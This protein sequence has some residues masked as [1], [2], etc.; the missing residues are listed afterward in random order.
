MTIKTW[1]QMSN[2]RFISADEF[3]GKDV[4]LTI[5]DIWVE[6]LTDFDGQPEKGGVVAF[7]ETER[8]WRVNATNRAR[9]STIWP[10]PKAAIGR[11]VTLMA[12]P[13]SK[14]PTGVAIRVKGSPD[15]SGP[16]QTLDPIGMGKV[17]KFTL[18]KTADAATAAP[19]PKQPEPEAEPE[20]SA[21]SAACTDCGA[22]MFLTADATDADIAE[23]ACGDCGGSMRRL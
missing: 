7:Q 2:S 11:K 8:Q 13:E 3:D 22:S 12:V 15:L 9:L 4:T 21:P 23:M 20:T 6:E 19:E 10:K 14:S 17:R 5:K 16:T 1:A 18:V